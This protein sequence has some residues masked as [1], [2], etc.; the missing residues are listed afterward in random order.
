MLGPGPAYLRLSAFNHGADYSVRA[1]VEYGGDSEVNCAVRVELERWIQPPLPQTFDTAKAKTLGQLSAAERHLVQEPDAAGGDELDVELLCDIDRR[2]GWTF[3][4]GVVSP[5]SISAAQEA[6]AQRLARLAAF[7]M[8]G[9]DR[10][11]PQM[12]RGTVRV[13]VDPADRKPI[14]FLDATRTPLN[15]IEFE[16][17]P[18]DEEDGA[19][20]LPPLPTGAGAEV[21]VLLTCRIQVDGSLICVGKEVVADAEL[22]AVVASAVR[23]AG[24]Q[25]RAAPSLRNGA[26]SAGRA[27]DLTVRVQPAF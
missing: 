17:Q 11:D 24:T 20:V 13:R 21:E 4:C 26:P 22:R 1:Q 9:V 10:D 15:D 19:R 14:D 25:Y 23:V 18:A 8:S 16:E 12:M 3:N 6:V 2:T 7:D 5:D 27:I